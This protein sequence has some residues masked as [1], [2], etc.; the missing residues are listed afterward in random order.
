M[1]RDFPQLGNN[2]DIANRQQTTRMKQA[3]LAA[4]TAMG[5]FPVHYYA[6]ICGGDNSGALRL[7]HHDFSLLEKE[8]ASP[9]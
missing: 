3:S 5:R 1:R 4:L 7:C 2:D 8:S 9:T 6:P